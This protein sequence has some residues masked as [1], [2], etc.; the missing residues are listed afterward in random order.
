MNVPLLDHFSSNCTNSSDLTCCFRLSIVFGNFFFKS[1]YD[2]LML[3]L[4][5]LVKLSI[6]KSQCSCFG[7]IGFLDL[8]GLK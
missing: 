3:T 6:I 2:L 4:Q 5:L 8:N 7:P 1:P